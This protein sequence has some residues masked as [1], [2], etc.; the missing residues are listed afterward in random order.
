VAVCARRMRRTTPRAH[1]SG[2]G[3]RARTRD[4][5][6]V[7]LHPIDA[8]H[9]GHRAGRRVPHILPGKIQFDA[10]MDHAPDLLPARQLPLAT[11][12]IAFA[13]R[14]T[15]RAL[16]S[17]STLD[18]HVPEYS[19]SLPAMAARQAPFQRVA[20]FAADQAPPATVPPCLSTSVHVPVTVPFVVSG[21]AVHAPASVRPLPFVALHEPD[22]LLAALTAES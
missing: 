16:G 18:V 7:G 9:H 20:D 2:R 3:C 6:G 13:K 10:R 15:N 21:T 19:P 22:Q 11:A 4:A 14:S 5:R 12:C 1:A 8:D 17:R